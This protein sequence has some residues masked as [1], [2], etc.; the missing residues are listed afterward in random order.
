METS[1]LKEISHWILNLKAKRYGRWALFVGLALIAVSAWISGSTLLRRSDMLHGN[2]ALTAAV[3]NQRTR[4]ENS[5]LKQ[6][7]TSEISK[8]SNSLQIEQKGSTNDSHVRR[9]R[10]A[11]IVLLL[12]EAAKQSR[13]SP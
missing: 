9:D 5:Y 1:F 6:Y 13:D 3:V 2:S 10:K 4:I 12:V 8:L 11:L 7:Q